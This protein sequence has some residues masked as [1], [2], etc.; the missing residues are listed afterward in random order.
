MVHLTISVM[1]FFLRLLVLSLLEAEKFETK[2]HFIN[3]LIYL[4]FGI[5]WIY[6]MLRLM[7]KTII[8]MKTYYDTLK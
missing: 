5:Y 4:I 1:V 6:F 7:K 3:S 8:S 2:K